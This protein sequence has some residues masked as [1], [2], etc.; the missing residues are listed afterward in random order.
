MALFENFPYTNFHEMNL[1]WLIKQTKN[2]SDD[3]DALN[4]YIT[5]TLSDA[6]IA[7]LEDNLDRITMSAI[8]NEANA[9]I[10]L[11]FEVE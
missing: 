11:D 6:V 8:Y 5:G 1:D 9:S 3:I 10:A 2:N 4:K 7:F